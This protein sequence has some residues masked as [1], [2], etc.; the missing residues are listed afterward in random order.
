MRTKIAKRHA[1]DQWIEYPVVSARRQA[2]SIEVKP[3][4]AGGGILISE[5]A[6]A[7][8]KHAETAHEVGRISAG[9]P[10]ER[11]EQSADRPEGKRG[12]VHVQRQVA[13]FRAAATQRIEAKSY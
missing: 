12:P 3:R 6:L 4:L 8:R 2:S 13:A 1:Q 10:A 9:A 7:I 11:T 5:G